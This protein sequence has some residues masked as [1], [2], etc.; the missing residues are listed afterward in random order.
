MY[1]FEKFLSTA[2]TLQTLRS[3]GFYCSEIHSF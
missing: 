1:N 2:D 3:F